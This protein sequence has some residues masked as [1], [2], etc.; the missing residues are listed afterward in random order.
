MK[1]I[2]SGGGFVSDVAFIFL[3]SASMT[4]RH[5]NASGAI[6]HR[7]NDDDLGWKGLGSCEILYR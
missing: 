7:V 2:R 3:C 4:L 6:L 1:L 5:C